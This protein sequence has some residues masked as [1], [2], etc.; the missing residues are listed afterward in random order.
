MKKIFIWVG[1]VIICT[2]LLGIGC[3]TVSTATTS[4]E[5]TTAQETTTVAE[6]TTA[7]ETTTVAGVSREIKL[8]LDQDLGD[9]LD[10]AT[11]QLL[12]FEQILSSTMYESLLYYD[13]N[14]KLQPLLSESWD[15]KDYKTYTFKLR[16]D[17]KFH[18]GKD[19]K[20]EDVKYTI[21]RLQNPETGTYLLPKV[22]NIQ[23][24]NILDDFTVEIV[25]KNMSLTFLDDLTY[26]KIVPN[27][28]SINL[29]TNPV[30]TGP[31][32]FVNYVSNDQ[33]VL[34]KFDQ[35]WK[36]GFPKSSGLIVK[37]IPDALV[38]VNNLIAGSIDFIPKVAPNLLDNVKNNSDLK[39]SVQKE[40]TDILFFDINSSIEPFSN[41]Q[42]RQA[43]AMCF[44]YDAFNTVAFGGYG[45]PTNNLV[46]PTLF[47]YKDVGMYEFNPEKAK[48][49]L[50]EQGYAD[51]FDFTIEVIAG[52]PKYQ[53]MAV[54]WKDG[55]DKAGIKTEIKESEVLVWLDKY[56][57]KKFQGSI[58][59]YSTSADALS[60]FT[61][62]MSGDKFIE[63][64]PDK[65]N[66]KAQIQLAK[67]TLD[68]AE[69]AKL[70]Q[71]Y[72]DWLFNDLPSIYTIF[73]V[74]FIDA[75]NKNVEGITINSL[76]FYDFSGGFVK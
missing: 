28:S 23:I 32:K 26:I 50:E 61:V 42:V 24:V 18:N 13:S 22:D 66:V 10:P 12:A 17:V 5:T 19:F 40:T 68:D 56:L 65:D 47:G 44:D 70:Y 35:Y 6:T 71:W 15:T 58:N 43:M 63:W 37:V 8:V 55:L 4:A 20:A 25:L 27:D 16:K 36:Q 48:E 45:V 60:F 1:I 2:S 52:I 69:R 73:R 9:N 3:K 29:K 57:T 59:E 53:Q 54:I 72:Q 76:G 21:S 14:L 51:G 62:V 30:G 34:S 11:Q 31:F 49:I 33:I 64:D 75:M 46:S 38:A 74:P 67:T 39:V 7:Q 41:K